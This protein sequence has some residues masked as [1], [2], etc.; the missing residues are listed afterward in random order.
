M[1]I[2]E[3]P[4]QDERRAAGSACCCT[5]RLGAIANMQK[6]GWGNIKVISDS[7][8]ASRARFDKA[9]GFPAIDGLEA[10]LEFQRFQF[11]I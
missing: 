8:E 5:I 10:I 1:E 2:P 9:Q 6:M 11:V 3:V 7:L 4:P